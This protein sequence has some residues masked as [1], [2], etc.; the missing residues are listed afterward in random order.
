MFNVELANPAKRFLKRC[1]KDLYERLMNRTKKLGDDPF[2][3]DIE[4]VAGKK[5]KV[6]RVRVGKYRILYVV[7]YDKN[8]ILISDIDKR[9]RVY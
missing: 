7:F 9:P 4:R 1:D 2:P 8:T 3:Q 6:F 5:D